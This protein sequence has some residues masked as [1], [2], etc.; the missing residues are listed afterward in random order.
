MC[1][2]EIFGN[3][4]SVWLIY[5]RVNRDQVPAISESSPQSVIA[6]ASISFSFHPIVFSTSQHILNSWHGNVPWLREGHQKGDTWPRAAGL[7]L[8]LAWPTLLTCANQKDIQ[9]PKWKQYLLSDFLRSPWFLVRETTGM[10]QKYTDRKYCVS[11]LWLKFWWADLSPWRMSVT[12]W[13]T[14]LEWS[15]Y[16]HTASSSF[17]L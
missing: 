17:H 4:S 13:F 16:S 15:L 8:C 11:K 12:L 6:F 1:Q 5:C 2:A 3:Q 10:S 9:C 14:F 7:G